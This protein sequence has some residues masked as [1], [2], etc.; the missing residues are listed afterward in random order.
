MRVSQGQGTGGGTPR[1]P[2]HPFSHDAAQEFAQAVV[3]ER[4]A[5]I[6]QFEILDRG[7]LVAELL[8]HFR[9]IECCIVNILAVKPRAAV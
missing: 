2:S 6:A 4:W 8:R 5:A 1:F 9:P 7:Q 3:S